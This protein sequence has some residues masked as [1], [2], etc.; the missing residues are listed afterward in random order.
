MGR[1]N[2]KNR[3][4]KEYKSM[5]RIKSVLL[6]II[7]MAFKSSYAQIDPH[8]SQYYANPLWLNPALTGILDGGFRANFNAK[9]QWST[10]DNGYST[11]GASVDVSPKNNFAYGLMIMNQ[12]AGA[13]SYNQLNAMASGAYRIRFGAGGNKIVNF[14]LQAGVLSKSIDLSKVTLGSQ[15]NPLLGFDGSI[16]AA[17]NFSDDSFA[18][19]DT[20]I[21]VV[22]FDAEENKAANVFLGGSIA[23]LNRPKDAYMKSG[24][25]IPVRYMAHGGARLRVNN[26]MDITPNAIY[27]Q[28]GNAHQVSIGAYAQM[29][30][31][32]QSDILFGSNYRVDDSAIAFVGLRLKTI[33]FG[34]SYD[35]TTSKLGK[36]VGYNGGLELS[37]SFTSLK[38]ILGPNFFCPRL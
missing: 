7:V 25:V 3:F 23:H 16:G 18:A 26:V 32:N 24:T 5:V 22:Y 28:Q 20:N 27:L 15:F 6:V 1:V 31:N 14:G 29:M 36:V 34:A 19:F 30:L 21:G 8:F 11:F 37:L 35:F 4:Q 33:V 2:I 10:L 38:G 13:I 17:E 12:R 9:E